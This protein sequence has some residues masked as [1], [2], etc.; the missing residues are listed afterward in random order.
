MRSAIGGTFSGHV[1]T[2]FALVSSCFSAMCRVNTRGTLA[3]TSIGLLV[4]ASTPRVQLKHIAC[5]VFAIM[6]AFVVY[7]RDLQ[8]LDPGSELRQRYA[9][10]PWWM[11]AHGLSG[12]LALFVAPFQ[13]S[14]RLRQRN[15][16]LHRL[17]GRL[18]VGGMLVA[19]PAAI[20]VAFI[21]GPPELFM[22]A[23]VQ[24]TAWMLTTGVALYCIRT[25]R[26]QQHR[27]WMIRSYPFAAVFVIARIIMAIPAVQN[28]G[29]VGLISVVWSCIAIALFLPS[30]A[31]ALQASLASRRAPIARNA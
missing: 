1:E 12:A 2:P 23:V 6:V 26:M 7:G 5:V 20:P 17:M 25:G 27:E 19:A 28:L 4:R 30:F 16:K 14:K 10:V 9:G 22:A 3:M 15:I 29:Q 21:L 11:L 31:L 24:S 8:L 18:Y 13:F